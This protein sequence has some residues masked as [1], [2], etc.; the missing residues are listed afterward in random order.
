[1]IRARALAAVTLASALSCSSP[2]PPR[3][4]AAPTEPTRFEGRVVHPAPQDALRAA[5]LDL[6]LVQR[7]DVAPT[8][9]PDAGADTL[10]EGFAPWLRRRALGLRE[11]ASRIPALDPRSHDDA[12]F[13]AVIYA[14]VADELRD[15]VQSLPPPPGLAQDAATLWRE[16]RAAQVRP[17][18]RHA[19]DAW[20]RCVTAL[21]H[22]SAALSAWSEP[23]AARVEALD[24]LLAVEP[25]APRPRPQRITLPADCEGPEVTAP[26]PDPEAPPPVERAPR[27]VALVYGGDR[28]HA[29][30]R[31]RLIAAVRSWAARAPDARLVPQ[32]EI[33]TARFLQLQRR[34]VPRGP[35]CGQA[36]P[37]PA[38]LATR[39][40]NLVIATISTECQEVMS[41]DAD[42]G[43]QTICTLAVDYRRAGTDDRSELPP[44]R[45]VDLS[46]PPD[47]IASWVEAAGRLGDPDAGTAISGIL[48][49]L[50]PPE[51]PVLRLLGYADVDPWLRVVPTLTRGGSAGVRDAIAACTHRLGGVGVYNLAWTLSPEGVARDVTVTPTTEPRDGRGAQV[52][53]CVRDVI[54]H[55]GFPCP[56][57]E[58]AATV[59]ARLCLGWM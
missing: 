30:E 55:A 37:L 57:R 10:R 7:A 5:Y 38:L 49:A 26:V 53:A 50:G 16:T 35:V 23:C 39:H 43:S 8:L 19:R 34:W 25:P 18:A 41:V 40:R 9:P 46:G 59:R 22:A 29:A 27:T 54:A 17:L 3:V 51:G 12:V 52:S 14:T 11:L 48:G 31:T 24:E 2:R 21:P 15:A 32:A 33:E 44:R 13:A 28:F 47:D 42:A 36:P 6:A 58:G 4:S 1:M 45:A 56:R 20:Q